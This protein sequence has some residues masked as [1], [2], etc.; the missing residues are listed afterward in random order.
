MTTE[1]GHALAIAM[2]VLW[3]ASGALALAGKRI[4]AIGLNVLCAVI[5]CVGTLIPLVRIVVDEKGY[6]RQYGTGALNEVP[7]TATFLGLSL[8]AILASFFALRR[9]T[10]VFIVGWLANAPILSLVVYLAFWWR[11]FS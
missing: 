5:V 4:A 10:W 9:K 6:I 2:A 1:E 11:V 3:V 8:F 7:L